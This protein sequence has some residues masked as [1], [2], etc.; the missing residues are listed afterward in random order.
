MVL[1]C[2]FQPFFILAFYPIKGNNINMDSGQIILI[3]SRLILGALASFFAI[4]LW[5]RTRNPAWMFVIIGTI[6]LYVEVI[7][8]ILELLGITT[9][10]VLFIGSVSIVA[11][12]LPILYMLFFIIALLIMIAGWHKRKL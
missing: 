10:Y 11:V 7:Y 4:M 8:S 9:G 1:T 6:T 3:Y 2:V 5:S 12:L